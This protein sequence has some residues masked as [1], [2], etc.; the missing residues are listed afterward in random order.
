MNDV[1]ISYARSSSA[2]EAKALR[3]KLIE[4]GCSVFLM[5]MKYL[6]AQ[7]FPGTSQRTG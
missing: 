4:K 3:D 6:A 1:F 2:Q 7:L 5:K